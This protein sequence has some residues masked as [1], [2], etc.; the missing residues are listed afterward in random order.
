MAHILDLRAAAF[1]AFLFYWIFLR[2]GTEN[3]RLIAFGQLLALLAPL[4]ELNWLLHLMVGR[5]KISLHF[6]ENTTIIWLFYWKSLQ[7]G[8]RMKGLVGR[9][10]FSSCLE[11][12]LQVKEVGWKQHGDFL[13]LGICCTCSVGGITFM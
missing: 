5:H 8:Y 4:R 7:R 6:T 11:T 10:I 12:I 9:V 13:C 1:R 2:Q 3:T